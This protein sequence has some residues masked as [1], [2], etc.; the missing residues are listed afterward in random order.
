MTD[1]AADATPDADELDDAVR[2]LLVEDDVE[3]A[4]LVAEF[5][6]DHDFDVVIEGRGDQVDDAIAR[7]RPALIILD[8]MLPGKD[9]LTVCREIR[10][11]F[12]GGIL[13]L[14]A[15]GDEIDEVVGLEI[16]ADDYLAKPVRPRVLLARVRS[17]LRRVQPGS[18]SG[19]ATFD[20]TTRRIV[21]G[22]LIVD[23]ASRTVQLAGEPVELTTME[24]DLLAL[25]ASR[26]GHAL[27]RDE[28]SESVRGVAWDGLDRAVDILVSRLRAKLG[29]ATDDDPEHHIRIK[30]V[31]GVGYQL[32]VLPAA[33]S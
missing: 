14:T 16:G 15:R 2:L 32:A 8:I 1:P 31:R 6:S 17:L 9:G 27:D 29:T 26:V 4:E 23:P 33:T 22:E 10:G 25:L 30:S 18:S 28:I 12:P 11:R 5:L 3:L 19:G 7:H 24:F 21:L 20:P 13:M